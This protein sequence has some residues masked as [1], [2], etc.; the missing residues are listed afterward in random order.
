MFL[1]LA[2]YVAIHIDSQYRTHSFLVL[3]INEY[4]RLMR[5]D[6]SGV[7]FTEP[8]YYDTQPEFMKFFEYYNLA[9]P[10]VRGSDSIVK[11]LV[12]DALH[13]ILQTRPSLVAMPGIV[14]MSK[15]FLTVSLDN[16]ALH[17]QPHHYVIPSPYIWP[18][19]PVGRCT[20]TPSAYDI[21][22]CK[23]VYM[24]AFWRIRSSDDNI[25]EG[26]V[27]Q[28][29]NGKNIWNIPRY[30]DFY[31]FEDQ[32]H[33]TQ[34]HTFIKRLCIPQTYKHSIPSRRLHCLI[35]D[36]EGRKLEDFTCSKE[37]VRAIHAAII[38]TGLPGYDSFSSY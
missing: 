4:A 25:K 24:K 34:T 37:M 20:R 30:V 12:H 32:Y 13:A 17:A 16:K 35:L 38:G 29:L 18:S 14:D 10:E 1:Q 7:I 31:D 21:Q 22:E 3:I 6:R 15:T 26:E 23:L 33:Q 8:I 19:L 36:T 11:K 2:T 27:Y 9:S 5:W 28:V